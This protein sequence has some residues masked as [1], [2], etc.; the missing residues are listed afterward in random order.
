MAEVA[1]VAKAPTSIRRSSSIFVQT[2]IGAESSPLRH[3]EIVV[4]ADLAHPIFEQRKKVNSARA[5]DNPEELARRPSAVSQ[6]I[7][8]TGPVE[9]TRVRRSGRVGARGEGAGRAT[10]S[11]EICARRAR[12]TLARAGRI[13]LPVE[14]AEV[15]ESGTVSSASFSIRVPVGGRLTSTAGSVAG[16]YTLFFTNEVNE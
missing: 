1:D 11:G 4:C 16:I 7:Q 15:T 9:Q 14:Y 13:G 8:A 2:A 6:N 12:R 3:E 10:R 5:R